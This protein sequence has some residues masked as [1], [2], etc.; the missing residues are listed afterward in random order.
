ML[1]ILGYIILGLLLAGTIFF[2]YMALLL[3]SEN[4]E[5]KGKK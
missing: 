2:I 4:E 1:Y 5:S 3:N